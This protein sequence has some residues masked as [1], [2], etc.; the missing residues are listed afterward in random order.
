M[1]TLIDADI[2]GY[3]IGFTTQ[4]VDEGIAVWRCKEL[5]TSILLETNADEY[6]LWLSDTTENNF[7]TRIY[8]E[9]KAN[10]TQPKPK[11]LD[12]LKMYMVT[13]WEARI[14]HEMEADDA[15]GIEQKK[16]SLDGTWF[17]G[18]HNTIIASIDKDL[19]QVPGLHYNFVK[20][21]FNEI[22]PI[23]GIRN[24][25]T[26][27]LSGDAADNVKGCPKI[28]AVK[29]LQALLGKGTEQQMFDRVREIYLEQHKKYQPDWSEEQVMDYLLMTGRVLKIKQ[30]EDEKLWNF[31]SEDKLLQSE[32][33]RV[34]EE[35]SKDASGNIS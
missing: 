25:Y 27:V 13:D 10:R 22:T 17:E 18:H 16:E 29:S 31:P 24:F 19:L 28:G 9:Y 35:S 4:D 20:K 21:E 6:Q 8:P 23:E 11:H 33:Q 34:P 32:R 14:A 1:R 12:M 30:S 26:Q 2:V 15:L 7:R 5:L 3:R